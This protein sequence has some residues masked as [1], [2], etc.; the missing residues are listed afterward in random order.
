MNSERGLDVGHVVLVTR[1]GHR[2][3]FV[4]AVAKAVVRRRRSSHAVRSV[5]D[6]SRP[7]GIALLVSTIPPSP[8][9]KFLVT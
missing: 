3:V 5:Q 9:V 8:V 4:P 1:F 6:F 2:V 7:R